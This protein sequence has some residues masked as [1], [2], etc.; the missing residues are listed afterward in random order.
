MLIAH[1]PIQHAISNSNSY[2]STGNARIICNGG[3]H[4][5]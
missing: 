3:K 5:S 4:V 2:K 1:V